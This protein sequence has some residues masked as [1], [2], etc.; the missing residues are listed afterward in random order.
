VTEIVRTAI[1]DVLLITPTK[2]GDHRGFFSET[3][4]RKL[5]A[6]H[7]IEIDFVQDNQSLSA[8]RGVVR[9]LHFQLPPFAQTKLVRVVRG[10]MLDVAVDI[11][12]SSPTFGQHVAAVLSAE[13]WTQIL[14]PH[15]FAHGFVTLEP[16]TEAVY[17]VDAFY[18]PT[19]DR[20]IRWDDPAL[21]I[22]WPIAAA[23]AILSPKDLAQPLL[24]DAPDLFD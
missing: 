20:G 21:G 14:V 18:A 17:K 2:H 9:G 4:N 5:L 7:G 10:S 11:R 13:N 15:G 1:P 12:R 24:A 16:N 22:D 6:E 8:E 19:H 23:D 3:Y